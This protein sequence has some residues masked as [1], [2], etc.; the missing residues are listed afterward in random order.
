MLKNVKES[1]RILEQ[2]GFKFKKSDKINK[3]TIMVRGDTT[4]FIEPNGSV[5]N[6]DNKRLISFKEVKSSKFTI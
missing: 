6:A 5:V 3:I 1:R 2:H 4:A